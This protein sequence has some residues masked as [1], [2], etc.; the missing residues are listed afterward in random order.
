MILRRNIPGI[1]ASGYEDGHLQVILPGRHR[2]EFL[3]DVPESVHSA[4]LSSPDPLQYLE[5]MKK[6]YHYSDRGC[7]LG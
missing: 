7:T 6:K 1:T 5:E 4:L 3:S 2:I